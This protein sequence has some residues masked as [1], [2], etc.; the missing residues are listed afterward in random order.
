MGVKKLF[1][2]K[3]KLPRTCFRAQARRVGGG[4][5]VL[6]FLRNR[7]PFVIATVQGVLPLYARMH[8]HQIGFHLGDV[9]ARLP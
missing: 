2:R 9:L 7:S 5:V 8:T 3:L 1:L 4:W 6:L